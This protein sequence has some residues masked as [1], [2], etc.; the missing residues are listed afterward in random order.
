MTTKNRTIQLVE[1]IQIPQLGFGTYGLGSKATE[2][3]LHALNVGY[4]HIDTADIYGTHEN[5]AEAIQQSK[6]KRG[7][8]FITS[9]LWSHSVQP[10]KVGHSVDK[11]LSEL[12]TEYIDLLLI[13][14]PSKTV[15]AKETLAAMEKVR[16]TGKIRALGVSNFNVRQMQEVLETGLPVS[17]NQIQYNLSHRPDDIV[18]FCLGNKVTVTAYS[19]VKERGS[20]KSGNVLEELA[21]KY[22]CSKAEV[23]LNWFMQKGMIVIPRS[24]NREH[25]EANFHSQAWEMANADIRILNEIR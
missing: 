15:P 1:D 17:N 12:Q 9:K 10:E 18:D 24:S 3:V 4:R 25:I 14:W 8:I 19:P 5:I 21:K 6:I 13:H 20:G 2:A 7:E 11:F 16:Q 22:F 23:L